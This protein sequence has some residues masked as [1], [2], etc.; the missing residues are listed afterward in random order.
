MGK[1]RELQEIKIEPN[2]GSP[3]GVDCPSKKG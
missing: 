2:L 3:V 1:K